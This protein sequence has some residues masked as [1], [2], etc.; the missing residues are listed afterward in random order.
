[1]TTDSLLN[2]HTHTAQFHITNVSPTEDKKA[3]K[4][5]VKVRL[6][7]FRVFF[8]RECAAK[9]VLANIKVEGLTLATYKKPKIGWLLAYCLPL[10]TPI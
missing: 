7:I 4:V 6:D 3:S 10:S 2:L 5:K 8:V 9:F 1:M